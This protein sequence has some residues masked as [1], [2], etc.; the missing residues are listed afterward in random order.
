MKN[1]YKIA[2]PLIKKRK[3]P[4]RRMS[5]FS[6]I[7]E[8]DFMYDRVDFNFLVEINML[9]HFVRLSAQ[10]VAGNPKNHISC[11][12]FL[13]LKNLINNNLPNLN[14]KIVSTE[15]S[16]NDLDDVFNRNREKMKEVLSKEL[17]KTFQDSK[18]SK[19]I[20]PPEKPKILT[21]N[22]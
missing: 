15:K 10:R 8:D 2:V 13:V 11:E 5:D 4:R 6:K 17:Q 1:I 12:V 9:L 21:L 16:K 22:D 19:I 18:N 20:T 3:T 14:E 7:P